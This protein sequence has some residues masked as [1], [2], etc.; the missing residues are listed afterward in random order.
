ML[1]VPSLIGFGAAIFTTLSYVPQL[2]K[3]W[4]NGSAGD[5][6]LYMYLVLG[7]GLALWVIYG[8]VQSDPVIIIANGVSLVLLNT[9]VVF[10]IREMY[11]AKKEGEQGKAAQP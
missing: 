9:I 11:F 4:K 10:K 1:T 8:I 3:C 5:L 7:A 2:Y 6:S